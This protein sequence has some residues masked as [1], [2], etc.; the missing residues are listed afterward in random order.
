[1]D[2]LKLLTQ[3]FRL[4]LAQN[5]DEWKEVMAIQGIPSTNFIYADKQGNIAYYYNA[6]FPD[7]KGA[8]NWRSVIA[9]DKSALIPQHSVPF[10]AYP[11]LINP[12]SGYIM[13]ANN[14]PFVA[15]RAMK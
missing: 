3:Y 1:M 8:A 12:A 13:N 14:T 9:G 2:S 7:R 4:N 6:L 15:A 5:F 11:A 10:S